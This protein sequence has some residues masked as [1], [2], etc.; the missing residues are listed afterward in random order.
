MG[1]TFEAAAI[2]SRAMEAASTPGGEADLGLETDLAVRYR[3]HD[4]F[5]LAL[6]YGVLFPGAGFDAV[7]PARTA[8]TAQR[9]HGTLGVLF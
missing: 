8:T 3:S 9:L 5:V 1:L 4:R 6:E 2:Y 7:A